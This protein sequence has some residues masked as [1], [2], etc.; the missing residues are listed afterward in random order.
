MEKINYAL[1]IETDYPEAEY[2]LAE[3]GKGYV[4]DDYI[5][6][7]KPSKEVL[8]ARYHEIKRTQ[9]IWI[10]FI[11]K[12]DE[13]LAI[14][15]RYATMDFPHKSEEVKQ[16]WLDYRQ[17]LRD[18]PD[19]SYPYWDNDGFLALSVDWPEKPE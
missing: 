7:D 15:D 3:G 4:Y 18:L 19:N 5:W 16:A 2:T 11:Q 8:D 1:V 17:S 12:R 14:T 6:K 13:L 9:Y 10:K